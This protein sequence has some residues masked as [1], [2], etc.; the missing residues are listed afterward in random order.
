MGSLASI[1]RS[2]IFKGTVDFMAVE[3]DK[4]AYLFLPTALQQDPGDEKSAI[5]LLHKRKDAPAPSKVPPW[6]YNPLH[7]VESVLWLTKFFSENKD[8]SFFSK[9]NGT[10]LDDG[11]LAALGI[12]QDESEA[13]RSARLTKQHN[14]AM[15]LFHRSDGRMMEIQTPRE[16]LDKWYLHPELAARDFHLEF[17]K[18]RAALYSEYVIVERGFVTDPS[19]PFP[20]DSKLYRSLRIP[21]ASMSVSMGLI[22]AYVHVE[23]LSPVAIRSQDAHKPVQIFKPN[24]RRKTVPTGTRGPSIQVVLSDDP[25]VEPLPAAEVEGQQPGTLSPLAAEPSRSKSRTGSRPGSR[26]GSR[27][28]SR[29]GLRSASRAQDR[30]QDTGAQAAGASGSA[31]KTQ[32]RATVTQARPSGGLATAGRPKSRATTPIPTPAPAPTTTPRTQ[33]PWATQDKKGNAPPKGQW[34]Y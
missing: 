34:R 14:H 10:K 30:Q 15:K 5:R 23:D 32:R 24:Y 6:R 33:P 18:M 16:T 8:I 19:M 31:S 2:F 3:V 28:G 25:Q 26:L 4:G 27:P 20:F 11:A 22:D 9:V 7:D 21:L 17:E 12:E 1:P 13:L 29:T